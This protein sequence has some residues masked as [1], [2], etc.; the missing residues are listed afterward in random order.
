MGTAAPTSTPTPLPTEF[1]DWDTRLAAHW[2]NGECGPHGDNHNWEWCD[3]WSF[4]CSGIV[5]VST[6]VCASGRARLAAY[7]DYGNCGPHG[8]NNNWD[9]CGTWSFS[10]QK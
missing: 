4:N 9:W 1:V 10:C 2:D 7:W 6:Q 5:A 3:Q 8:D